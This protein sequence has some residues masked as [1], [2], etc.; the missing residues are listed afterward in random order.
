[1]APSKCNSIL[2]VDSVPVTTTALY[3]YP[4]YTVGSTYE[5]REVSVSGCQVGCAGKSRTAWYASP[6]VGLGNTMFPVEYTVLEVHV[7]LLCNQ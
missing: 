1:M 6:F 7:P 2:V 4:V 3:A 5:F